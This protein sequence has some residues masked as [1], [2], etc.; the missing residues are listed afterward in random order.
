MQF[1]VQQSFKK[2]RILTQLFSLTLDLETV[3][4]NSNQ[5]G[6]MIATFSTVPI[7]AKFLSA[8]V[9]PGLLGRP[10]PRA[11]PGFPAGQCLPSGDCF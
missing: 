9:L 6:N 11:S 4:P 7:S 5:P 3:S 8:I 2:S 10:S 1:E